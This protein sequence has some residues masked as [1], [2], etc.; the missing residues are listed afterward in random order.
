VAKEVTQE[1]GRS[2]QVVTM[3]IIR[4]GCDMERTFRSGIHPQHRPTRIKLRPSGS[5]PALV[6]SGTE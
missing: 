3:L 6:G 5:P 4:L 2:Y 1:D